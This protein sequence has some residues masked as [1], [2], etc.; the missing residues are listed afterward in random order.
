M[1]RTRVLTLR[2][3]DGHFVVW[4][5]TS[6]LEQQA[7]GQSVEHLLPQWFGQIAAES[8]SGGRAR[9]GKNSFRRRQH[10]FG[11]LDKHDFRHTKGHKFRPQHF[12]GQWMPHLILHSAGHS[13][14]KELGP[15]SLSLTFSKC[16][17]QHSSGHS[18]VH[19][20]LQVAGHVVDCWR[21][22][23]GVWSAWRPVENCLAGGDCWATGACTCWGCGLW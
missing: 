20:R 18:V 10:L 15:A 22:W 14:M 3:T 17:A 23:I 9:G 8:F 6:L 7:W 16:F 5:G 13:L 12:C 2:Q 21:F 4:S 11:Q 1:H 19:L